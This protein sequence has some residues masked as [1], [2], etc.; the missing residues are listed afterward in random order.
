MDE[1]ELARRLAVFDESSEEV[2][3]HSGEVDPHTLFASA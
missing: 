3:D 2:K 1:E